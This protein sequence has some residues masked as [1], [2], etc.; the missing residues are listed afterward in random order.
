[1]LICLWKGCEHV[2]EEADAFQQHILKHGQE[3]LE[4]HLNKQKNDGTEGEE[5]E[6]EPIAKKAKINQD[7]GF[8]LLLLSNYIQ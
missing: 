1:M 8:L 7:E 2:F 3:Q 4:L 6:N 5:E